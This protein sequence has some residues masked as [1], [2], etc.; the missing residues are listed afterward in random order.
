VLLFGVLHREPSAQNLLRR[1]AASLN[2]GG[3]V[4]VM[5]IMTDETRTM[6]S[7]S[8]LFALNLALTSREGRVFSHLELQTWMEE[9]G[10]K[11]FAVELLPLPVPQWLARGRKPA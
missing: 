9:A 6:P 3:V 5:E 4:Y 11:D 7:F 8:A 2:P 1:A 10:L